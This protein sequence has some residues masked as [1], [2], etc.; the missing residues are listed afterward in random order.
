MG[1]LNMSSITFKSSQGA[2]FWAHQRISGTALFVGV[3]EGTKNPKDDPS[4]VGRYDLEPLSCLWLHHSS[5]L[6]GNIVWETYR[7]ACVLGLSGSE[8]GKEMR[9]T[10]WVW[11]LLGQSGGSGSLQLQLTPHPVN[12]PRPS[13]QL[14]HMSID[15]VKRLHRIP[16]IGS[17]VYTSTSSNGMSSRSRWGI[18]CWLA[19]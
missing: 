14:E 19:R 3:R 16:S 18:R 12:L 15:D 6:W 1:T 9:Y 10:V 2:Q 17:S 4:G 11:E 7:A 13:H 5:K 8:K